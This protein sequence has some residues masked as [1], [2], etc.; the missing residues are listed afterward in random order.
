MKILIFFGRDKEVSALGFCRSV[1]SFTKSNYL[2]ALG[3][4]LH[5]N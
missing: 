4:C 1:I 3:S 2:C 5:R